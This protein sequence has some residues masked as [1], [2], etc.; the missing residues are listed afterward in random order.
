MEAWLRLNGKSSRG[1]LAIYGS[2]VLGVLLTLYWTGLVIYHIYFYSLA[3]YLSPLLATSTPKDI[4]GH[5]VGKKQN[6]AEFSRLCIGSD[7]DPQNH[8]NMKQSLTAAFFNKT[9]KIIANVVDVFADEIGEL[10][11]PKLNGLNMTKW[12]AIEMLAFDILR[13]MA[14]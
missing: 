2:S 11:E 12:Y 7:R 10:G 8:R 13:E 9:L 3:S 6:G 14:F 4:Y 5:A 1:L